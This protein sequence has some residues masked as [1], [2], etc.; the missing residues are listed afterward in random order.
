M[1][2]DSFPLAIAEEGVAI[3]HDTEV[4]IGKA[5]GIIFFLVQF[6]ELVRCVKRCVSLY[7]FFNN[8]HI[9]VSVGPRMGMLDSNSVHELML[10]DGWVHALS[11]AEG[12]VLSFE[13]LVKT[14][15]RIAPIVVNN[16]HPIARGCFSELYAP[17]KFILQLVQ[18]VYDQGFVLRI[19]NL[20]QV[21]VEGPLWPT[22][23]FV[24]SPCSLEIHLV[25]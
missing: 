14:N 9:I 6:L 24:S 16:H 17:I 1:S 20:A 2:E 15:G 22:I 7:V 8:R 12:E 18:R 11:R 23:P 10:N 19:D 5:K 21:V 25:R 4:V 3:M 13:I